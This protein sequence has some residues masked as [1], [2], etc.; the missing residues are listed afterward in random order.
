MRYGRR[1]EATDIPFFFPAKKK[2]KPFLFIF[3][4]LEY[5]G[6]LCMM[7]SSSYHVFIFFLS[8]F[9]GSDACQ[10]LLLRRPLES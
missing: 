8:F 1:A 2:P 7:M 10:N 6:R 3:S 9:L 5:V 4:P